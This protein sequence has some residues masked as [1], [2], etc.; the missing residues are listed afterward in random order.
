MALFH[1][2]ALMLAVALAGCATTPAQPAAPSWYVMRHLQKADGPDP[3]LSETGRANAERLVAWFAKDPP[4]AIYVSATRRARET[5]APLAARL[6]L[7]P[8]EYDPRDTAGLVARVKAEAG[9]VL[10]VGHS[11]TVP[12]IVAGLGGARPAELGDADFGDIYRVGSDG[13]VEHLR[14]ETAP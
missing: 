13:K 6:G 1:P 9:T 14:I 2:L 12:E 10:I 11:N 3:A 4:K 5:A 7:T 8:H